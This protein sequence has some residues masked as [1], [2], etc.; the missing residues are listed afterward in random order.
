MN[1]TMLGALAL[2]AGVALLGFLLRGR[3]DETVTPPAGSATTGDDPD[4]GDPTGADE[5][6][7]DE[8]DY[9]AV[10]SDGYAFLGEAHAVRIVATHPEERQEPSAYLPAIGE[11]LSAGDF[12]AAR[13]VRGAPG[14]DPWRLELLGRDGEFVRFAFE[15]QD[16]AKTALTL[17]EERGVVRY[18]L[19]DDDRPVAHPGEQFEE[20][21][22]RHDE[23]AQE[24]A[25]MPDE[26]PEERR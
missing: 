14:V 10:T 17:L 25:M 19:D 4:D 1:G 2:V 21:R 7:W 5:P 20:A 3:R 23:I 9:A 15:T 16:G 12:T 22:R 11:K 24:L 8:S 26:T 13:I 6:E 18:A